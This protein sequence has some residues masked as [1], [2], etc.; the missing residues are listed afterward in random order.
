MVPLQVRGVRRRVH[1]L[2]PLRGAEQHG[3]TLCP[4]GKHGTVRAYQPVSSKGSSICS[5]SIPRKSR[6][7]LVTRM[8]S[9]SR[10]VAAIT[11]SG[12][13]MP[14]DRLREIARSATGAVSRCC[15][16]HSTSVRAASYPSA[17]CPLH[18]RNSIR[19]MT[20][21]QEIG[22]YDPFDGDPG[23]RRQIAGKHMDEDV[24]IHQV[25]AHSR[26]HSPR[27]P[28]AIASGSRMRSR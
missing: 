20:E 6:T 25:V 7:F 18:P 14:Q 9:D 10:A 11:A 1:E 13:E 17:V 21:T 8:L 23:S 28:E 26:S 27:R 22:R 5:P 24:R 16:A 3:Q 19:V 2:N 15:R 12:S 4:A